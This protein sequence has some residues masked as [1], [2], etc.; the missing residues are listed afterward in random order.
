MAD[1]FVVY[2]CGLVFDDGRLLIVKHK[3]SQWGNRWALPG[4]RLRP[5]ERF[6]HCV[7]TMVERETSCSVK[8][9]RQITTSMSYHDSSILDRHAVLIFYLCKYM[10]GEPRAGDGIEAAIWADEELFTGLARDLDM[11][12]QFI[13]AVSALCINATSFRELSFDFKKPESIFRGMILD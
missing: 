7:E 6:Q 11:P 1:R 13:E 12:Y 8:A 10:Y 5:G 9:V 3:K 2:C 4:G